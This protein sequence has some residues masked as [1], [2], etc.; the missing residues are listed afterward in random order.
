[1]R[2]FVKAI[3]CALSLGAA[4]TLYSADLM[5]T[6]FA[7]Y[8]GQTN[9]LLQ[10]TGNV[11]FTGGLLTL[12]ALP[13]GG[14]AGQLLV[15][16]GSDIIVQ[17][18]T[19][20]SAGQGWTVVF[21]AGANFSAPGTVISG[22]G[23]ITLQGSATLAAADGS[24]SFLAGNGV[25]VGTGFVHTMNGG[26]ISVTA[27]SGSV[28]TGTKANGFLFQN[29]PVTPY[30]VDANLG[31][32][33]TAAGGDVSITAGQ[34]IT[35]FLP[36]GTTVTD[37]GS[38]AFGSLP[39]NVTLN[40]GGNVTGHYVVR[41]GTGTIV[42][43]QSAG[44]PF[45]QLAL[46]LVSGSWS[47]TA[48]QNIVL[49]EV[50]NPNGIFNNLGPS[51]AASQH[52]F[53]YA[54]NAS[55]S[56]AAGNSVQLYGASLPRNPQTFEQEIPQILPGT[57]SLSAG[58]GGAQIANYI[59][60]FPSPM[61]Q[62]NLTISNG[63]SLSGL[64]GNIAQ[65]VMSDSA[66][67][68]YTGVASFDPN[69][70]AP[71]PLHVNDSVPV[72]F[73][74]SGDMDNVSFISPK[75]ANISVAGNLNS[76]GFAIQ[77]LHPADIASLSVA[78]DISNGPQI[79]GSGFVVSGPGALNIA[80]GNLDLGG[81]AGIQSVGPLNNQALASLGGSGADINVRLFGNLTMISN[82]ISS[83][84]GGKITVNAQGDIN[85]GSPAFQN[86]NHVPLGIFTTTRADVAVTASGAIN[87]SGSR[88]AAYDGGNILTLSSSSNVDISL[89]GNSLMNVTKVFGNPVQTFS[90]VVLGN[91]ILA[92][93]LPD[94]TEVVGN[95][96]VTAAQDVLLG[97][98]AVTQEPLNG[99]SSAAAV[100][101]IHAGADLIMN[102]SCPSVIAAGSVNFSAGGSIGS[103]L[104]A[105]INATNLTVVAG[106]NV[107]FTVNAAGI[108]PFNYQWYKDGASLPAATNASLALTDVRRADT[109]D[110]SVIVSNIAGAVT[111]DVQL[112]VL[113]PQL[114]NTSF[115]QTGQTLT[116]SF[117]DADGG[118]LTAQDIAGFV[119]QTS[120]NL[121]DWTPAN[122]VISTNAV[123]GLSFQLPIPSDPGFGFYRL[124]SQ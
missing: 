33:S 14:S 17:S 76:A 71:F 13:G 29:N 105:Q 73:M 80:A 44:I 63:G 45:A 113:V 8:A 104:F 98:G 110:Y 3:I 96:S 89:P 24:I 69:D 39:G 62:L 10:A 117:G 121:V 38:G 67:T 2:P 46:S 18:S 53:D 93:T 108:A 7:S 74:I 12:P 114:L 20:I 83:I 81:S 58:S 4:T 66:A 22:T 55:V 31:G 52:L 11:I 124:Q 91:G 54:P 87:L 47:V 102:N 118:L 116:V 56:L 84:A 28:N 42:A 35:S 112:R 90:F 85:A 50:R 103:F 109:G 34:D 61:G 115:D 122:L 9:I 16:A 99:T 23:N 123:G 86:G 57:L 48:A 88:I 25:A 30:V 94:S 70:H 64:S 59:V 26:G 36:I 68:S 60:M 100:I 27:V 21:Q 75:S 79:A 6:S 1:M 106:T 107:Q 40:A 92:S 19:G 49:Q 97:C 119:I 41:N 77:N 65:L 43:G 78:G 37:G 51:G 95:I 111:N 82:S 15:Q 72:Q 120:T 101:T 32:V 5:V